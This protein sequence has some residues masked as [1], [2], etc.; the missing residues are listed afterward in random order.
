MFCFQCQETAKNTGCTVRGMCGKPEETANLQDLLIFVLKGM[1][2]YAEKLKE[3][4]IPDRSNDLFVVQALFATI[5]NANWNDARFTAWIQKALKRRDLLRS[6]FLSAY[7]RKN[8]HDF[9]ESLPEPATWTGDASTFAEKAKQV[10]ILAT[11]NEDVRSLRELLVI[12]LKGVSAYTDHAAVL[13]FRKAEINDF[14]MQGLASTTKV[15][16]VD[17]MVRLVLKCGETAVTAMALLDEANTT[18]YGHPEISRVNI[19]GG[20]KFRNSDQRNTT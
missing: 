12:G 14:I 16:S 20:K 2:V 11:E 8:G 15:L 9:D 5:T 13:G 17:E 6:A 3:L 7:K 10:G 19:E 18:T 1:A 4:G